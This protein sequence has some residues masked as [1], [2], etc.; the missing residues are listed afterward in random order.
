MMCEQLNRGMEYRLFE[1]SPLISNKT[2]R[3]RVVFWG[4]LKLIRE[5][6]RGRVILQEEFTMKVMEVRII[7]G[8][9]DAIYHYF[10]M[11]DSS[12]FART[13]IIVYICRRVR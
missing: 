2:Q 11:N 3:L 13:K 9:N 12:I 5:I 8:G 1:Y 7:R 10:D 6:K 4:I